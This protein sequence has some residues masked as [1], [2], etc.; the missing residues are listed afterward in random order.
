ML[1]ALPSVRPA[2]DS[3]HHVAGLR[4]SV[5]DS[6]SRIEGHSPDQ[7]SPIVL[8]EPELIGNV[9]SLGATAIQMNGPRLGGARDAVPRGLVRVP[10]LLL[11]CLEAAVNTALVD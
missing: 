6:R 1:L 3:I 11:R 8:L 7:P 10:S 5:P 9:I 4:R 2:L